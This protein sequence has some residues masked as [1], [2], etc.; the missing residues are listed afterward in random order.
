MNLTRRGALSVLAAGALAGPVAATDSLFV[1]G[2]LAQGGTLIG[3]AAPGAPLII[4]GKDAGRAGAR[5]WFVIGFD[6]DAPANAVFE[7]RNDQGPVQRSLTI[8]QGTF[9]EQRIDGLP[10]DQVAPSDP[11]LLERIKRELAEKTEALTSRA[12]LEGFADGFAWPL[13]DFRI[14]SPWGVRRV[15]NGAPKTPHYG[16]DLAAPQGSAILAPAPGVVVLAEPNMHFEGGLTLIDHGQ[17]LITMYL[18]QSKQV[19]AKG[20]AVARGEK[21][22]EV[23]MTGRATGPHLCWRMN[24]RDRHCDP[25][26]LV[27]APRLG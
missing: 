7:T 8:A 18:H 9:V 19:V 13:K 22:G 3:R 2:K 6:R 20:Q 24:W 21:I 16:I 25:S 14:S 27:D 4:D 10:Q 5:G 15:L 23:G 26:Q 17:G 11:K 1:R 12:D